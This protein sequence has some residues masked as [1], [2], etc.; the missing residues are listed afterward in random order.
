M[1]SVPQLPRQNAVSEM[2]GSFREAAAEV[3]NRV[4][5]RTFSSLFSAIRFKERQEDYNEE[6][7]V[8]F[9]NVTDS[10]ETV[11]SKVD[12]AVSI[13]NDIN[14]THLKSL[15]LLNEILSNLSQKNNSSRLGNLPK[16]LL[17]LLKIAGLAG[18]ALTKGRVGAV[19]TRAM[20]AGNAASA[21]QQGEDSIA[22]NIEKIE[23]IS[24]EALAP[25][26]EEPEADGG[27][28]SDEEDASPELTALVTDFEQAVM[29]GENETS[30]PTNDNAV[31]VTLPPINVT[32][33]S[34][35]KTTQV[36]NVATSIPQTNMTG[37]PTAESVNKQ[38]VASLVPETNG[39]AELVAKNE[40]DASSKLTRSLV[41]SSETLT[42]S[43]EEIEFLQK[44]IEN[45]KSEEIQKLSD[46]DAE[47]DHVSAQKRAKTGEMMDGIS[48]DLKDMSPSGPAGKNPGDG[49]TPFD[50]QLNP[51]LG[52]IRTR[53]GLT[54]Q[55]AK[56][57]VPKFQS[58]V[59]DLENT[60]YNIKELGGYANRRNVN[61]PSQWS[62]HAYGAAI[63]INASTNP[64]QSDRTDMPRD[65]VQNLIQRHGLGWGLN[66]NSVKDP[67][68]FSAMPN[69]GGTGAPT[70]TTT[71]QGGETSGGSG[72]T[73][74]SKESATPG[75]S[76]TTPSTT[77]PSSSTPEASTTQTDMKPVT[78]ST[79]PA[80]IKPTPVDMGMNIN[81]MSQNVSPLKPRPTIDDI[82]KSMTTPQA[83][84]ENQS[85]S[86][87]DPDKDV[88]KNPTKA[89]NVEPSDGNKRITELF[90]DYSSFGNAGSL[91]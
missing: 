91:G 33:S 84:Q 32:Q 66:W 63:D 16:T 60:G 8:N 24:P 46:L 27:G 79:P 73:P 20:L 29:G 64:N 6:T 38:N 53:S 72:S 39:N 67:M 18:I 69:E 52:E 17:N 23:P 42:F 77:T 43:A 47:D 21:L 15:R 10:L 2:R 54:T 26:P 58:F 70:S 40:I 61:N 57:L 71:P 5:K 28:G 49:S 65:Q 78:T 50:G 19:A 14:I 36:N 56:N 11:S 88:G 7:R 89:G 90:G 31:N 86:F 9:R 4:L 30:P 75:V 41:F 25:Q 35:N 34:D 22:N 55:V 3:S 48:G 85:R 12:Y 83:Q 81:S 76:D 80:E 87:Y 44:K 13:L 82:L 45:V 59:S 68:H 51:E 62:A 37:V 74:M 1:A